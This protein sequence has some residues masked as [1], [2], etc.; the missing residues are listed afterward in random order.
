MLKKV[1]IWSMLPLT[2]Y[3][4][5][6]FVACTSNEDERDSHSESD[7]GKVSSKTPTAG[8][9]SYFSSG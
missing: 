8:W 4:I 7:S 1:Q 9:Y 2:T 5:A 3:S 6:S